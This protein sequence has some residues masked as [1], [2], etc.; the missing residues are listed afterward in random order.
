MSGSV[1]QDPLLKVRRVIS[2]AAYH[3]YGDDAWEIVYIDNMSLIEDRIVLT[4][5]QIARTS[6]E[7]DFSHNQ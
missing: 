4:C 7:N 3:R 1:V 6:I 5:A 2:L